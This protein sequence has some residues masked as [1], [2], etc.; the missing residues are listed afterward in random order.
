MYATAHKVDHQDYGG[1]CKWCD[2]RSGYDHSLVELIAVTRNGGHHCCCAV[3][4]RPTSESLGVLALSS[5]MYTNYE[6]L[7][8][9]TTTIFN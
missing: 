7:Y 5:Q 6:M 8:Y 4:V 3:G 1:H 2:N 9:I